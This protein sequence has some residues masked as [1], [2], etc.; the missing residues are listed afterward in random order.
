MTLCNDNCVR[1]V[2]PLHRGSGN[3]ATPVGN[4]SRMLF[5]VGNG[6]HG[7]SGFSHGGFTGLL[8]DEVTGQSAA[9][10]YGRE[11]YTVELNVKYI[12][13]LPYAEYRALSGLY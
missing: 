2:T 7:H 3:P 10:V 13:M 5:S 11:I 12:K 8:I 1:A 4:E 6:V 9:D